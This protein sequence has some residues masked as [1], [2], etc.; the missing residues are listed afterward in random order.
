[1]K[2]IVMGCGRIGSQVSELMSEQGHDVVVIDHDANA[3]GRLSPQFKGRVVQGLGFD[4]QILVKAGIE[5]ADAFV[6]ASSSDNANIVAAR[7]A[8][9]IFRVPR[10]VARLYDPRQA[11][12]YQRLGLSTISSTTWGAERIYQV[13]SHTDLD[14]IQTFGRGEV[15]LVIVETPPS[16]VGKTVTQLSVPG[17]LAVVSITRANEAFVPRAGTEFE[18]GDLIYLSVLSS[19]MVRLEEMLGLERR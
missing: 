6:A 14:V 10:V 3:A 16:L 9:N 5:Q 8:R 15:S 13:L 1:M 17:E 11:E 4:R 7:I 2:V 19:A 18:E 12:I